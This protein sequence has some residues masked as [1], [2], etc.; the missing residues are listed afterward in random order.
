MTKKGRYGQFIRGIFTFIDLAII[1]VIYFCVCKFTDIPDEFYSRQVW[2]ML[3]LSYIV[4]GFMFSDIHRK[5]IVYADKVILSVIKS[6]T[7]NAIIF[8]SLLSFINISE[9][10]LIVF[11]KLYSLL[12]VTFAIWW[13]GSRKMLKLYRALG[14]NFKRIIIIG[15]GSTGVKLLN[16]LSVDAG[17][18]YKVMGFFDD[19]TKNK[20]VENYKGRIDDVEQFVKD[21][22]IDE[23]Y[24][25][26]QSDNDDDVMRLIKISENNAVDFYFVPQISKRLTRRFE[27]FSIGNVPVLSLRP[28][29]LNL[30][31]NK[32]IKRLFDIVFSSVVLICS[33]IILIPVS[34]AIKMSSRGPILFKQK[35][36]G[37][38]G[39]E[40]TCYKFRTMKVNND[41]DKRQATKDDPRKTKIGEFLRKSSIDEL[42]QFYNVWRGDMSVVGPRP[43]MVKHTKD[44]SVLIDKY[45]VRHVIKPGITGWAQVNGLRGQTQQLWQ[46]EK[47]VEHDMWY[48]ENWNLM[49]DFK[50]IFLTVYRAFK[51][52]KN[53]F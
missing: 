41:S 8:A 21:N 12:F 36:T 6:I 52:D 10:P 42:P 47:R 26:I 15:G 1:N 38:R 25:T 22:L 18:G 29:P 53:A 14:F 50:I 9:I 20:C 27:L 51:G 16:E 32:L 34:I 11:V 7:L 44:Y 24:C 28:N 43:H 23:M 2:L 5:R 49:L 35:R 46:M 17:Y 30:T 3:N 19:S 33:P 48:T 37:Y 39:S 31:I 4:V 45:M 40:F 13:L